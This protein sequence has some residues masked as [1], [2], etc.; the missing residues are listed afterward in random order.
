MNTVLHEAMHSTMPYPIYTRSWLAEGWAEYYMYNV[1]TETV[2]SNT[3]PDI[4]QETADTYLYNGFAGYQWDPY[5][6]NDYHDATVYNRELQRSHGYD[7]TGHMFSKMVYEK[8]MSWDEFYRLMNN[9]K[10]SLDRTF[11]L[12]PPYIYYTDAFVLNVFGKAMGHID[13]LTETNPVFNYYEGEETDGYGYGAR[14]ILHSASDIPMPYGDFDWFGDIEPTDIIFSNDNPT[15]FESITIT[16]RVD[17]NGDVN[18]KQVPIRIC[19]NDELIDEEFRDINKF[20]Y[21]DVVSYYSLTGYGNYYVKIIVDE[22]LLKI[23]QNDSNNEYL[24]ILDVVESNLAPELVPIG[25]RFVNEGDTLVI[26]VDAID[27]D[28]DTLF[29]IQMLNLEYLIQSQEFL[30]GLRRLMI[31]EIILLHL[32]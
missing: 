27:V 12:G 23:E 28:N 18:M 31:L 16:S 14:N 32:M 29:F 10:E 1:L 5:V 7:I 13:W 24:E 6:A 15:E 19:V 20:N 3:I 25:N 4:N 17:N 11:S 30:S 26:D 22:E 9:N 21:V 2:P 8:G